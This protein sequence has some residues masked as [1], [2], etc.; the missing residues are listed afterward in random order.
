[1][2]AKAITDQDSQSVIRPTSYLRVKHASNLVQADDAVGISSIGAGKVLFRNR[3]SRLDVSMNG[4][5]P[6]DE[7]MERLPSTEIYSIAV[8]LIFAP[9]KFR[10]S[11]SVKI[12]RELRILNSTLILSIL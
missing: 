8:R 9:L 7:R 4:R 2:C 5:W 11:S 12:L 3:V 6:D 10:S 1:M